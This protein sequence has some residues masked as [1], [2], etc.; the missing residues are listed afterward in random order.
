MPSRDCRIY[1][2]TIC[3][4]VG[5]VVVSFELASH[6]KVMHVK[7]GRQPPSSFSWDCAEEQ[8]V[9]SFRLQ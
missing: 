2:S 7:E 1:N 8:P 5:V 4:D 6:G 3:A 9:V